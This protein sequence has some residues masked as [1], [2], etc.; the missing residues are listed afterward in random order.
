MSI[1]KHFT[2]LFTVKRQTWTIETE[3]D[4]DIDKSEETI[5]G[6]FKGFVQQASAQYVQSLGLTFTKAYVIWCALGTNVNDGDVLES[7]TQ[8]FTVRGKQENKDGRNPHIELIVEL[9]G[10]EEPEGSDESS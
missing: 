5:I 4:V 8:T 2:I 3:G 9:S 7:D 6:T 10:D 1:E